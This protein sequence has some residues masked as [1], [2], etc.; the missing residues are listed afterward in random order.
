M[1]WPL[2]S[3]YHHAFCWLHP[4]CSMVSPSETRGDWKV[5]PGYASTWKRSSFASQDQ[6]TMPSLGCD[7]LPMC[8]CLVW[9]SQMKRIGGGC[10]TWSGWWRMRLQICI[11]IMSLDHMIGEMWRSSYTSTMFQIHHWW[12]CSLTAHVYGNHHMVHSLPS[13]LLYPKFHSFSTRSMS[14]SNI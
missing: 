14:Y 10:D 2:S 5:C 13:S 1:L 8:R 6:S 11:T 7:V 3:L 12:A 9:Q 4:P